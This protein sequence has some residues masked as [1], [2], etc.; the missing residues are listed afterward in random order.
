MLHFDHIFQGKLFVIVEEFVRVLTAQAKFRLI[1]GGW[2]VFRWQN[3]IHIGKVK[4]IILVSEITSLR[5]QQH[6]QSLPRQNIGPHLTGFG[7]MNSC[8]VIARFMRPIGHG[9]V[10]HIVDVAVSVG[11]GEIG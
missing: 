7:Y 4:R 1:E 5:I 9:C 2:K 10:P 6:R 8:G 11:V 3:F